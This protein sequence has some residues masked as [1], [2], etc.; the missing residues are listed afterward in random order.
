MSGLECGSSKSTFFV[1]FLPHQVLLSF[2]TSYGLLFFLLFSS[3]L[4]TTFLLSY[5]RRHHRGLLRFVLD[6]LGGLGIPGSAAISR[7][8][9]HQGLLFLLPPPEPEG[10]S[11]RVEP[12]GVVAAALGRHL[13]GLAPVL[14]GLGHQA[15]MIVV[16]SSVARSD[17]ARAGTPEG[18]QRP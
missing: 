3:S 15:V 6:V 4:I 9:L 7:V 13:H 2:F 18:G 11:D 14:V 10:R 17:V 12:V 16:V 8:M 5:Q 1:L